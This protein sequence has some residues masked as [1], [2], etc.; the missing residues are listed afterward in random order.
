MELR[1][2]QAWFFYVEKNFNVNKMT[3]TSIFKNWLPRFQYLNVRQTWMPGIWMVMVSRSRSIKET[4]SFMENSRYFMETSQF[5]SHLASLPYFIACPRFFN[6]ICW[7]DNQYVCYRFETCKDSLNRSQ[8]KYWT[9][10]NIG[11]M[12]HMS[13]SLGPLPRRAKNE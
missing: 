1:A 2:L 11:T 5:P 3:W 13:Q 8:C 7:S 10:C 9:F 6:L 12:L 4:L